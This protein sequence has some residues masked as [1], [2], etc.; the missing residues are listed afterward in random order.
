MLK[1][2]IGIVIGSLFVVVPSLAFASFDTNLGYGASGPDV[3]SLQQFLVSQGL[4]SADS[5]TGNFFSLTR[6]AVQTL[7]TQEGIAPASGFFGPLT[8]AK[9]NAAAGGSTSVTSNG[10]SGS[11][12]GTVTG[13]S[14]SLTS[15]LAQLQQLQAQLALLQGGQAN[16]SIGTTLCTTASP[17]TPNIGI[18][19]PSSP[20]T[21]STPIAC[22]AVAKQ[23]SDGSYVSPSG[24][25][26]SYTCP[27]SPST[28][29]SN[30]CAV[31]SNGQTTCWTNSTN[32]SPGSVGG[33]APSVSGGTSS[34]QSCTVPPTPAIGCTGTAS[35]EFVPGSGSAVNGTCSGSWQ[36]VTGL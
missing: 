23:C 11:A 22:P 15:L 24:P 9:V 34:T 8:R 29:T 5:A 28:T 1:K 4:L 14:P 26:C 13:T 30:N 36:C 18:P 17:C 20:T 31:S 7:Q 6:A 16:G 3:L 10:S 33:T 32:T 25:N 19:A 2:W 35:L 27:S 12:G 21:P